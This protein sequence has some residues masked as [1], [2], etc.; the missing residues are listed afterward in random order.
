[1]AFGVLISNNVGSRKSVPVFDSRKPDNDMP[2]LL[3]TV[4]TVAGIS[5]NQAIPDLAGAKPLK[6]FSLGVYPA[7]A[8][9]NMPDVYTADGRVYWDYATTVNPTAVRIAVF[10]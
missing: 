7:N 3:T 2:Q 8:S 9:G 1:M 4:V 5:G 10:T 6:E